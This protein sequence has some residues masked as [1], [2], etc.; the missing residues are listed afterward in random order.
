[1]EGEERRIEGR[2]HC[3]FIINLHALACSLSRPATNRV[4]QIDATLV[5]LTTR[6]EIKTSSIGG[7][8]AAYVK[9]LVIYLDI[10]KP[11]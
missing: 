3:L 10:A 5:P 8:K 9:S 6:P 11:Q 4:W 1:M 2:S 7:G